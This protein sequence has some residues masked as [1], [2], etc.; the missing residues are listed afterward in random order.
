MLNLSE[1][2]I[3]IFSYRT[4]KW[5]PSAVKGKSNNSPANFPLGFK[6]EAIFFN[7]LWTNFRRQSTEKVCSK[8]KSK[9]FSKAK[10]IRMNQM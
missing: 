2:Q 9:V 10:K 5:G 6:S 1:K 8:I 7:I 4:S 3:Q